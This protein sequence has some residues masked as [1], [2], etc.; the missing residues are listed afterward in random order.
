MKIVKKLNKK[1]AM[2]WW[3]NLMIIAV[4]FILVWLVISGK[5][6]GG[7]SQQTTE[8][9]VQQKI[10]SCRLKGETWVLDGVPF[11]DYDKDGLPNYCDNCPLTP[12]SGSLV[13]DKDG[14]GF[15]IPKHAPTKI[16]SDKIT[17]K[18]KDKLYIGLCC[19]NDGTGKNNPKAIDDKTDK[20]Y[21]E[22]EDNDQAYGPN[23]LIL[24]YVTPKK[25]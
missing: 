8:R 24:A 10:D 20:K 17:D 14:D 15:P 2:P 19:G 22:T 23:K 6:F 9:L 13:E 12:N 21:C 5:I 11:D 16:D 1:G 7:F 3:M 18:N 4:V 25:K